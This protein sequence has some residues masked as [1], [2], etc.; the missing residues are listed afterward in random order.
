MTLFSRGIMET[1]RRHFAFCARSILS[2]RAP[3]RST[4]GVAVVSMVGA[5]DI[6][7]YLIAIQS[8]ARFAKLRRVIVLD[9]GD[10]G[11]DARSKIRTVVPYVEFREKRSVVMG[12]LQRGNVW[13]RLALISEVSNTEY[14][15]QM[16]S[17]MITLADPREVLVS[18]GAGHA[19]VLKGDMG[20]PEIEPL[21]SSSARAASSEV[22]HPQIVAERALSGLDIQQISNYVRGCAA[23]VGFPAGACTLALLEEIHSQMLSLCGPAW[24]AWG[25]E[26]VTSNIVIANAGDTSVLPEKRFYS[27]FASEDEDHTL[28]AM[29]HF[30]G[31]ARYKKG[32]YLKLAKEILLTL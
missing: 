5:K 16:D 26:Q 8:F 11:D 30:M 10:L 28:A 32:L 13:E 7:N 23:L 21:S 29:I 18:A 4:S 3:E 14:V 17:D 25:S 24:L 1:N 27:H 22:D 31:S 15:V 12:S 9:G 2:T 19:F 6:F 20:G